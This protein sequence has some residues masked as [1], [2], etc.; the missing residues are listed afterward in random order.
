[1]SFATFLL[2]GRGVFTENEIRAAVKKCPYFD[3][4]IENID[5]SDILMIFK[6]S[7]QQSWL[8]FTEQRVY[9]VLDDKNETQPDVRW[10]RVKEK[11]VADGRVLI[12]LKLE[13]KS[14]E[15]GRVNIGKMNKGFLYSKRLF[16][17]VG[18]K[19]RIYELITKHMLNQS[20]T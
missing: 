1:M 12:N 11:L 2:G 16:Y 4:A 9:F 5:T 10:R 14:E 20:N 19:K 13:D 18:I 15:T 8:V 7:S 3:S 17:E 6:T